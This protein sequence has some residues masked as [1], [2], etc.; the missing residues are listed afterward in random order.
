MHLSADDDTL[1]LTMVTDI[2][3]D[4]DLA[5]TYYSQFEDEFEDS[6]EE[7]TLTCDE[8]DYGALVGHLEK[9][10]DSTDS[11]LEYYLSDEVMGQGISSNIREQ[12]IV[13]LRTYPLL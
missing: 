5:E 3:E 1:D 8:D 6:D 9:A 10:L 13:T 12:K 2:P 4:A 11:D 7:Q